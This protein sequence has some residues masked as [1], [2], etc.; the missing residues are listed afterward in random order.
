MDVGSD[1]VDRLGGPSATSW[2]RPGG[3]S[4]AQTGAG[5]DAEPAYERLAGFLD[6]VQTATEQ[7]P[8]VLVLEDLHWADRSS[9][10]LL[11][12]LAHNL[13]AE[14]VLLLA[15]AR[16]QGHRPEGDAAEAVLEH[17]LRLPGVDRLA[18]QPLPDDAMRAL[19]E[20]A[21]LATPVRD[22][23]L[24]VLARLARAEGAAHGIDPEQVHFHEV[25]ALDSL[26]DVVGVSAALQDRLAAIRAENV[27]PLVSLMLANNETGAMQPVL[28]A[29][30]LVH[31]AGAR[32]HVDAVYR[33]VAR[34][35]T[36]GGGRDV[37][38]AAGER[39]GAPVELPSDVVEDADGP[40]VLLDTRP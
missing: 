38:R 10:A 12:F 17:L 21:G 15:T 13:I 5:G 23:A 32:L 25:G 26:A 2:L 20:G 9:L 6:V 14:R 4:A 36:E 24:D 40:T 19:V 29:A 30:R 22:R 16:E 31:E 8:L 35:V 39:Q 7:S 18:L 3:S 34:N 1:G 37:D 28:E 27:R 33:A 11:V